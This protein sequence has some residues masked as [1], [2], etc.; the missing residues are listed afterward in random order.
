MKSARNAREWR[1]GFENSE[2]SMRTEPQ[3]LILRAEGCG[4]RKKWQRCTQTKQELIAK[5]WRLGW[6]RWQAEILALA[7]QILPKELQHCRHRLRQ[8]MPWS[9]STKQPLPPPPR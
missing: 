6:I 5:Q 8:Q 9:G 1:S 2:L 3:N 4:M 7:T